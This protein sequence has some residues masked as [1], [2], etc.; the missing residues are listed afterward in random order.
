[1]KKSL[2]T[3]VVSG[4]L[5]VGLLS[6]VGI[7][8]ASTDAGT[9]LQ[10]WY[11]T[12][13]GKSASSIQT[14]VTNYATGKV[15]AISQE[16]NALRTNA[17]T[18]IN[19]TKTAETTNANT[20][21]TNAKN[22][23]LDALAAQKQSIE[24]S[25]QSQFD[26]IQQAADTIIGQVGLQAI[27]Y[28]NNDLTTLTG[29]KGSAA[30]TQL[31]SDLNAT[32]SQALSDLQAAIATSKADLQKQLDEASASRVEAIQHIID[33]KIEELR[34]T[35]TTKKDKL[36]AA[37]QLLIQNKAEELQANALT[38]LD[39]AVSGINK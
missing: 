5:A 34:G 7:A 28:A 24:D 31:T 21:I 1:M 9:N 11:N 20:A 2:K 38:D 25:L 16:Y 15:P 13:F 35:I 32:S 6:S 10:N 30:L 3:K 37:Q 27:Q 8:F 29:N 39:A 33:H 17:T 19:G 23:H 14:Q 12:Q 22:E 4:A 36:V 26:G 18:S